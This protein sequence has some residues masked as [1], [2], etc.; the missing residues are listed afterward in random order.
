MHVAYSFNSDKILRIGISFFLIWN[1]QNE[2]NLLQDTSL[3]SG[4]THSFK[5]APKAEKNH[6]DRS[7]WERVNTQATFGVWEGLYVWVALYASWIRQRLDTYIH[8]YLTGA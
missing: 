3:T 4:G 8:T 5:K 1:L 2:K 7:F 6:T